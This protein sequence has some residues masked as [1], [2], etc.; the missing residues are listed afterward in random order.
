MNALYTVRVPQRSLLIPMIAQELTI[1]PRETTNMPA[2]SE[3]WYVKVRSAIHK[4]NEQTEFDHWYDK[5]QI[6]TLLV[7]G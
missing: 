6:Q 1:M 5:A 4:T 7:Q 2:E 3:P